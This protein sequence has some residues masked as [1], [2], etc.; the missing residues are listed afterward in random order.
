MVVNGN[1]PEVVNIVNRILRGRLGTL[2]RE[3]LENLENLY[4][5]IKNNEEVYNAYVDSIHDYDRRHELEDDLFAA[6]FLL[7]VAEY[8]K[9]LNTTSNDQEDDD[10]YIF[11]DSVRSRYHLDD[12]SDQTVDEKELYELYTKIEWF[13]NISHLDR[14]TLLRMFNEATSNVSQINF[15]KEYI[16][17]P[18]EF[19]NKFMQSIPNKY[20]EGMINTIT[21]K[22]DSIVLDYMKSNLG[23]SLVEL[24]NAWDEINQLDDDGDDIQEEIESI[25]GERTQELE[26]RYEELRQERD[27]YNA[28]LTENVD[29]FR[30]G[31]S[32]MSND[33]MESLKN[34]LNELEE[35]KKRYD[36]LE[37]EKNRIAEENAN[38]EMVKSML[39]KE[40]EEKERQRIAMEE[41]VSM[42]SA[43]LKEEEL[44]REEDLKLMNDEIRKSQEEKENLLHG[45]REGTAVKREEAKMLEDEFILSLKHNMERAKEYFYYADNEEKQIKIGITSSIEIADVS[46]AN[47]TS[48]YE[49][50]PQNRIIRGTVKSWRTNKLVLVGVNNSHL[51]LLKSRRYDNIPTEFNSVTG[52]IDQAYRSASAD[53]YTCVICINSPTGFDQ[54]AIQYIN[55]YHSNPF[56]VP[57]LA[58][59]G[60][61]IYN[62]R[63]PHAERYLPFFHTEAYDERLYRIVRDAKE[64]MYRF[65]D[66]Q[67]STRMLKAKYHTEGHNER[68]YDRV[69]DILVRSGEGKI[70][71]SSPELGKVMQ[72]KDMV[73]VVKWI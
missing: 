71:Y 52:M 16:W 25:I 65:V 70:V 49:G 9:K 72:R 50:L 35:Q 39:Q 1:N 66:G 48:S 32:K 28:S 38:N 18:E 67:I 55:N 68:T 53:K 59:K 2:E 41:E 33:Y 37:K 3:S 26:K 13:W 60:K 7:D 8:S 14:E 12:E 56:C 34:T 15:I 20:F 24:T 17:K 27:R 31:L 36:E 6:Y 58:T 10:E 5:N 19:F 54:E 51:D 62:S 43:R 30:E 69:F 22:M 46:T 21:K 61:L 11:S 45:L 47:N 64:M 63:D 44:R 4:S 42:L 57:Y 40:W 73:E 23:K 29:K